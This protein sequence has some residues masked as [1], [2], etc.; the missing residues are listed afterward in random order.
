MFR[1]ITCV[2]I[3]L[4]TFSMRIKAYETESSANTD[5]RNRVSVSATLTSSDS[6]SLEA[7]YHYM[8]CPYVGIGGGFGYWRVLYVEGWASGKHWNIASDSEEPDNIY[9]RPSLVVKSPAIRYRATRWS[10]YAEAGAMLNL[11]YK[12]VDIVNNR[13]WPVTEY[14][15]THT[16]KGQWFATDIRIGINADIGPCGI[17][18]GYMY[19]NLDVYSKYRHLS[20]HG[21]SFSRFYESKSFMQGAYLALSF[22][23]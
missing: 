5:G 18:A 14:D 7:A 9:L 6:Y 16:N 15:S 13:Y 21:V 19:S 11:P 12:R 2:L 4:L 1:S 20:Y 23:F 3:L 10:L 8:F 22:Q 17:S